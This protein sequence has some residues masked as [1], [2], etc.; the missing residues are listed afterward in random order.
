[1]P[2]DF[3]V[4]LA[5]FLTPAGIP[6]SARMAGAARP[7]FPHPQ[8]PRAPLLHWP[9]ASP[10][11]A[12]PASPE[13]DAKPIWKTSVHLL[14]VPTGATATSRPQATHSVPVSPGG[15]V[16]SVSS[17][18]S[19]QPTPAP[20]AACAWPHTPRSSVAVHLA[21]RVTPANA[22]SMSASWSQDPALRALPAITPWAPSSVSALW[23]RRARSASSGRDPALLEAVSMEGPASWCR[24]E[25]PPFI[26]ASVPQVSRV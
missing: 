2:L 10:A 23:G 25:T 5:S 20:M 19:A 22:T 15:Q 12:P 3:W 13:S 14:S 7:C 9:P 1:M 11:P 6:N 18:T 24:R 21:S 4:R 8:A 16:S 17:E 26:S